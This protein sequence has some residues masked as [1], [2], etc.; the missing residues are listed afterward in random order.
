MTAR[1]M[2]VIEGECIHTVK[3]KKVAHG[4]AMHFRN[5]MPS[6]EDK[7]RRFK[8]MMAFMGESYDVYPDF[9]SCYGFSITFGAGVT[10]IDSS[11]QNLSTKS[12]TETEL[13]AV[14]R[15]LPRT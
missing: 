6:Y 12:S 3:L 13:V 7:Y 4:R 8:Q 2:V 11:K 9:R 10:M 15:G 5:V 14:S 1:D